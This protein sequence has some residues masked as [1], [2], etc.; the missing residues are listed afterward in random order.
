MPEPITA[1]E[2]MEKGRSKAI[3]VSIEAK[4]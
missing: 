1:M 4:K 2:T 3:K